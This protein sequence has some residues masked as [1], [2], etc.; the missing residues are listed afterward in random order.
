[1]VGQTLVWAWALPE[2]TLKTTLASQPKAF[3]LEADEIIAMAFHSFA[4]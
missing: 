4:V 2:T 3:T 1:L